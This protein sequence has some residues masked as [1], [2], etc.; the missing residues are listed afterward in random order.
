MAAGLPK[1][2]V[3]EPV[4]FEDITLTFTAEEWGLLDLKQK[5]LYREVMLENYKNLLS[6]EHQLS[7]PDVVSQLEEAE[8]F[9]PV[10][11]DILQHTIPEC[12]GAEAPLDSQLSPV[13]TENPLVNI[14]VVEVLTLNQEVAG[15]RNAQIQALYAE[16]SGLTTDILRKPA[17]Q[18]RTYPADP[19]VAHQKFRQFQYEEAMGAWEAVAQLRELC[20][21]WLQPKVHS[22][23]QILEL[24]V[25]EQFL[26]ALPGKFRTW[27]ELQHPEDC[28]A[29][30]A[31]VED[32][33][34]MSKEGGWETAA[35]NKELIPDSN[36]PAEEPIYDPK[37]NELSREGTQPSALE[38]LL[39]DGITEVLHAAFQEEEFAEDKPIPQKH[40]TENPESKA[41]PGLDTSQTSPQKIPPRKC[42]RKLLSQCKSVTHSSHIKDHQKGY[43]PGKARDSIGHMSQSS[44][45]KVQ[46]KGCEWGKAG[47]SSGQV[48]QHSQ[49]KLHRKG[50][51]PGRAGES[52]GLVIQNSHVK[53]RQKPSGQ[54]KAGESNGSKKTVGQRVP[55]VMFIKIHSG[56]Q[57]CRC[58]VCGKLFR[59][60]RYFSVHKKIHTGEKPYVCQDCGKAFVQSSSL[61]QHQRV[62]SGERPFQCQE[63]GRTFN[64]RSAVTQHLRTHTGAKP[65][66]C[67]DCGKAFRQSSHLTRHHR[68][69]TG[70][71]PYVCH[72]CGKAFTQSSHLIGHQNTHGRRK[73]KRKHKKQPPPA[74]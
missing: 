16:D 57:I 22:K 4:V 51:E 35:E 38:D 21:Q 31:L 24:L 28:Q 13:P 2:W 18:L 72:K 40:L 46:Q 74:S 34:S 60:P 14:K 42:F 52:S 49:V 71:R 29:A 1:P 67:Q 5:S 44:H 33:I 37:V 53:A 68:T 56:S 61:T 10:E 63:C 73:H 66:A 55:Q 36:V 65:Y 39:Q 12:P 26:G 69:H 50:C 8:D 48:T 54:N 41:D 43:E 47:E 70:E 6:V 7:K 19:E 23:E 58:S 32:V 45:V 9:W 30:I 20:Q 27:V 17:Q 11:R 64:D 15:P 3:S 59:N 25:L 62:H